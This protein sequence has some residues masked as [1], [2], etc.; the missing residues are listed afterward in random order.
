LLKQVKK[1]NSHYLAVLNGNCADESQYT[2]EDVTK[3]LADADQVIKK[4]NMM[5]DVAEGK[6]L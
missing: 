3:K 2:V 1:F 6:R 5:I 4:V